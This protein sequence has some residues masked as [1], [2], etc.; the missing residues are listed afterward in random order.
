MVLHALDGHIL[1]ILDALRLEHLGEG[2]LTLF[3]DEAVPGTK[4]EKEGDMCQ[5][6]MG[7]Q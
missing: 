3:A 7:V 1:A 5:K 2:A 6:R 4:E